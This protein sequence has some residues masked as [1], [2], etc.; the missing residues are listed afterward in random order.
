MQHKPYSRPHYR[1][2][3][4]TETSYGVVYIYDADDKHVL[5]FCETTQIPIGDK[6]AQLEEVKYWQKEATRIVKALNNSYE[7]SEV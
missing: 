6:E 3:F 2:P 7:E 5:D 4:Y 1:P